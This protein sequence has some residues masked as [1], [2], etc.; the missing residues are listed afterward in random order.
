MTI[1]LQTPPTR[2]Q[3]PPRSPTLA[4]LPLGASRMAGLIGIARVLAVN[5]EPDTVIQRT[6]M[7]ELANDQ[8]GRFDNGE[9]SQRVAAVAGRPE[10]EY[11]PI[12]AVD[13]EALGLRC[14]AEPPR[15]A[16]WVTRRHVE[17]LRGS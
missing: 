6:L 16:R 7:L 15:P 3:S 2:A 17:R 5:G 8:L 13:L 12:S 4:D 11:I 10:P 14:Q 1:T 9:V